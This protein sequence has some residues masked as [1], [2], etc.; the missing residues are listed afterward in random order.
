M[1]KTQVKII[2]KSMPRVLLIEDN[3]TDAFIVQKVLYNGMQN[4]QCTRVTTLE[5]GEKI[6]DKGEVDLLL[7][8]LGLPDTASPADTYARVKKWAD[9]VPVV[10]MTSVKDHDLS[11]VMIHDGA[12][13]F[14][15]KDSILENPRRIQDAVDFS[16]ERHSLSRKVVC[17]KEK[18]IQESKEKDS[19]LSCFMGGYS[20]S[21]KDN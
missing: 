1:D 7:L 11:R 6:L 4:A 16:V 9:K 13:D 21:S 8:D 14:L 18:A 19:V 15:N 2:D 10:I 12:A 20:V 5:A 3:D 17:D